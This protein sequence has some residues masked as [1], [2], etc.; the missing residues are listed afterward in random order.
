M[1]TFL[2]VIAVA[3]LLAE[4]LTETEN[5]IQRVAQTYEQSL[6]T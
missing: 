2:L 3:Y 4:K 5:N 1:I 6:L